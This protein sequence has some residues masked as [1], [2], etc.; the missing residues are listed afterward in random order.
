LNKKAIGKYTYA[1][2][3]KKGNKCSFAHSSFNGS[4]KFVDP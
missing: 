2:D 3:I 4:R 1:L